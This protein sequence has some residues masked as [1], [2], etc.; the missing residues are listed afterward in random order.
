[1]LTLETIWREAR[2]ETEVCTIEGSTKN[3]ILRAITEG[4]RDFESL[5]ENVRLCKNNECAKMNPSKRGCRENTQAL[6]DIYVPVFA[7]MAEGGACSHKK[8]APPESECEKNERP[9]SCGGCTMCD[10][11][12]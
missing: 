4:A 10:G 3:M 11:Q 1:M 8:F 7:I 2:P 12:S 5:R 9:D 6:L